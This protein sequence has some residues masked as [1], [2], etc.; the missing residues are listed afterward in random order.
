LLVIKPLVIMSP[1]PAT[2]GSFG[3]RD[4]GRPGGDLNAGNRATTAPVA[5]SQCVH[6]TPSARAVISQG[7]QKRVE[8]VP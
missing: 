2:D 7:T 4:H 8:L 3:R 6:S 1:K 5:A